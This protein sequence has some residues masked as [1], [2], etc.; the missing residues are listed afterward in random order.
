[1]ASPTRVIIIGTGWAGLAA[2]K[3]YLQVNPSISLTLLSNESSIGGVWSKDRIY[4]SLIAN[5]PNGL[6]EFT[7]LSMVE[8]ANP[9]YEL[10]PGEQVQKYLQQYA[11]KFDLSSKI[12]F[13]C[14]V[15]KAVRRADAPGW[16]LTLQSGETLSCD[17]LIVSTGLHNKPKWPSVPKDS[18]FLGTVIHSKTLGKQYQDIISSGAKDIIIV[19]GCKSAIEASMLFLENGSSIKIHWLVRPSAQGVPMVV[20]DP[21][22]KPNFV[23]V[24]QTR[25]FSVFGPTIFN[26]SGFW[27]RLLH[28]GRSWFG[29][30]VF[31]GYWSLMSKIVKAGPEYGK[32][33]NSRRI[34]PQGS[35]GFWDG[36]SVNSKISIQVILHYDLSQVNAQSKA[37]IFRFSEHSHIL[38]S[39]S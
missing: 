17:K 14:E 36:K 22:M 26:T 33:E 37:V 2:A 8:A 10:V 35:T 7:D 5:S 31:D 32:S 19:G 6:Y 27:Y 1:M 21:K 24:A 3:T 20:V 25:L 11:A 18:S 23:A 38:S 30:K 28:S 34:E 12:K 16:I 39:T 29:A 15:T 9:Q 13:N 4:P